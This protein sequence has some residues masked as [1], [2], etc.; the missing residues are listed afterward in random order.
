MPKQWTN[1]DRP[2][3]APQIVE[4]NCVRPLLKIAF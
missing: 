4:T 2:Y 3:E 1:A